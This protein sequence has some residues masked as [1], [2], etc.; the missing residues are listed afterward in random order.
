MNANIQN[1]QWKKAIVFGFGGDIP[2]R[3]PNLDEDT[4][5][6]A[7]DGGIKWAKHYGL[8]PQAI[9]GDFDS[10]SDEDKKIVLE[11]KI[12]LKSFPKEKDKTDLELA[13][14]FALDWE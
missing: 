9:I 1:R 5:V 8:M 2:H 7:A 10:I 11:Q 4:L 14:D 6:L 12:L 13:V 3:L